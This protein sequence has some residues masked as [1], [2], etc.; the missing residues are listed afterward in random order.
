MRSVESTPITVYRDTIQF[1]P[2]ILD[3]VFSI[4]TTTDDVWMKWHN[5]NQTVYNAPAPPGGFDSGLI[6]NGTF[7]DSSNLSVDPDWSIGSGVASYG[8]LVLNDDLILDL[9]TLTSGQTYDLTFT[10]T[11]DAR[12]E[13][14]ASPDG[15]AI[16]QTL[17]A[18]VTYAAGT[19]TVT[20][21]ADN[22]HTQIRFRG[23][24]SGSAFDLDN[25]SLFQQ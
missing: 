16:A 25:V 17:T 14:K 1:T 18:F 6:L 2:R 23:S 21:T 13:L 22:N 3:E 12:F 10:T 11:N 9:T 5:V 24:T 15:F 19:H 7:D 8:G 20:F 4:A